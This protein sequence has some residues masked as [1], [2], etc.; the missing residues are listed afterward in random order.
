MLTDVA[1]TKEEDLPAG[2]NVQE[3][4][5]AESLYVPAL[6]PVHVSPF[7][8]VK[9]TLHLQS[10]SLALLVEEVESS[11]QLIHVVLDEDE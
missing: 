8:P 11:G 10:S 2:H 9:P 7:P 5:P 1:A 3:A 6:H 4:L